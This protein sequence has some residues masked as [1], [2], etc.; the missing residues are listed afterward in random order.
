[1]ITASVVI[2]VLICFAAI[3]LFITELLP[4]DVTAMLVMVALM[5]FGIVTPQEG[6][7]GFS[8]VGT[9][10]VFALL[11]LSIGLESTGA[12]NYLVNRI[13]GYAS[14]SELKTIIA[15]SL[16]VGISSA[17][18]NNT[19]IVAIMLP[20]TVR[21]ANVSKLSVSKLLMPMSFAAMAGGCITI[22]GTSTNVIISGIHAERFGQPFGVFEFSL[23]GIILFILF[24]LYIT[25]IGRH[26]LPGSNKKTSL[27]EE[28]DLDKYLVQVEVMPNSSLIGKKITEDFHPKYGIRVLEIMRGSGTVYIPS[29]VEKIQAADVMNIKTTVLSLV[30]VQ[31]KLGLR[32][33]RNITLD[34]Q[35]LT[36]EEAVLFEAV[37]GNNSYLLGKQVK[38]VDFRQM[39]D[40]IPLAVR[41]SGASVPTKVSEVEIQ[42]GDTILLEARRSKLEKFYNSRDFIVLEKVKKP[43]FR[44]RHMILSA[45]IVLGVVLTA[46]T[47]LLPLEVAGLT[48]VVLLFVTGCVSPR[49]VYRKMEWRII[50]L[51][52]GLIPLGVAV[53]KSGLSNAI[54]DALLVNFGTLSPAFIISGLFAITILLTSFMSNNATAILLAPIAI[55][56]AE[57]LGLDPKAFLITIMFAASTSFL[58]PIG[59]QTNTLIYGPGKYKFWDYLKVGSLL[60]LLFWLAATILIPWLYL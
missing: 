39:F 16:L 11:V 32:I 14:D 15:I 30:E 44:Q 18:L 6:L 59:Y 28:Y 40:A 42:F 43:N 35:E 41:R 12:I 37:I 57:K 45:L 25:L 22:I 50:F 5:L 33:K 9:I 23:F 19:A 13:E 7:S 3:V 56:L 17:F 4:V 47:A 10:S 55:T 24:L 34:D 38:D 27:T 31:Q 46:S 53:E 1:M 54:A 49:F 21:L 60:T 51:L 58:T 29:D 20:I 8:N 48:G 2:V 36:S 26:L 52:A